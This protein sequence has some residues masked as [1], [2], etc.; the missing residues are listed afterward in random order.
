[1]EQYP[2]YKDGH[3]EIAMKIP[4]ANGKYQKTAGT[5]ANTLAFLA[6][7]TWFYSFYV[8]YRYDAS[9]PTRPDY[10]AGLISPQNDHGHVV[11][12]ARDEDRYITKLRML[13][14][15]LFI[16]GFATQGLFVE[17]PFRRKAPWEKKQW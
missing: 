10:A 9:R 4:L 3:P 6:L 11:Y 5:I 8:F 16:F 15:L 1:M 7:L 13:T 2:R 12:L 14:F 17:N